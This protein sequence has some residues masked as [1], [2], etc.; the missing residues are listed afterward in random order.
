MHDLLFSHPHHLNDT[1]LHGQARSLGLDMP[2]FV[3]ALADQVYLQG[4]WSRSQLKTHAGPAP[5]YYGSKP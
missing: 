4:S 2:R 5:K 3:A 1:D